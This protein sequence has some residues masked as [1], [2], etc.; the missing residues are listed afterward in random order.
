MKKVPL[1]D[2]L[3]LTKFPI[4]IYY[5]DY[6]PKA[7]EVTKHPHNDYWRAA[8]MMADAFTEVVNCHGGDAKV[9]HLPDLGIRGNSHFPF[10]EKNNVEV[11]G[12]LEAW[13]KKKNLDGY[14]K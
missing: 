9:V 6:V 14:A 3:K 5:G 11:A 10:A 1:E 4:V 12:A 7:D 13:L 8:A 2:F